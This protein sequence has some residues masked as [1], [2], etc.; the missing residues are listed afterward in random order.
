MLIKIQIIL[1]WADTIDGGGWTLVRHVPPGNKW[2]SAADYLTGTAE[3]GTPAGETA[4]K[5][6]SVRFDNITFAQFLFATG[7]KS[8]LIENSFYPKH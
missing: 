6:F 1:V 4:D 3:Y 5:E 7:K 8:L 2:H